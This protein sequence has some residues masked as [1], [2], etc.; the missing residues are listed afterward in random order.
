MIDLE[1]TSANPTDTGLQTGS[2]L[3]GRGG[4]DP[5]AANDSA[6]GTQ[7]SHGAS[8]PE[9]PLT[10]V[11]EEPAAEPLQRQPSPRAPTPP[12]SPIR[13][14]SALIPPSLQPS[15]TQPPPAGAASQRAKAVIQDPAK[16]VQA[17]KDAEKAAKAARAKAAR[18]AVSMSPPR[19]SCSLLRR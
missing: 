12:S 14:S 13:P 6:V 2:E 5:A 7:R 8:A 4:H 9:P 17:T 11:V 16:Q 1:E 19:T 10:T 3:G 18:G 15:S